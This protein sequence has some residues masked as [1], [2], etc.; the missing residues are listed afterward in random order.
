L[1]SEDSVELCDTVTDSEDELSD[2]D[3]DDGGWNLVI[4]SFDGISHW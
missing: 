2:N 4:D 3:S 1:L